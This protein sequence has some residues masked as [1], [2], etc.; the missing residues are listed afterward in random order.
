MRTICIAAGALFAGLMPS[1]VVAQSWDES[2]HPDVVE[3]AKGRVGDF[4]VGA[5]T[6][7]DWRATGPAGS[8]SENEPFV[9]AVECYASSPSFRL[10]MDR[11]GETHLAITGDGPLDAK[12]NTTYQFG[13]LNILWLRVGGNSY[14]TKPVHTNYPR[15]RFTDFSYRPDPGDD[16]QLSDF[17]GH[18]S[19]RRDPESPWLNLDYLAPEIMNASSITIGIKQWNGDPK[20]TFKVIP[21][22]LRVGQMRAAL[23]WCDDKMQ[24]DA[25]YHL[26]P[27]AENK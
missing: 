4:D 14:E 2:A 19:F 1:T 5:E 16:I 7:I 17:R 21:I 15:S 13:T 27:S 24:S 9:K 10:W 26:Y 11:F 23:K 6:R 18:L 8:A 25:A 20:N 12:G 22:K 3:F